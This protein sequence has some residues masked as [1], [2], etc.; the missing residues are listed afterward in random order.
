M[1][2]LIKAPRELNFNLFPR[3][4]IKKNH[5][6]FLLFLYFGVPWTSVQGCRL[7]HLR[8][9]SH[10]DGPSCLFCRLTLYRKAT[11]HFASRRESCLTKRG[12]ERFFFFFAALCTLQLSVCDNC[13]PK[14]KPSVNI[15]RRGSGS[16]FVLHRDVE[17]KT[18]KSCL[19]ER[20]VNALDVVR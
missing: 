15:S 18:K 19:D 10:K 1:L 11:N 5:V 4:I 8:A 9:T 14:L 2:A 20:N 6:F 17:N 3:H 13:A 16:V 12:K 7:Q